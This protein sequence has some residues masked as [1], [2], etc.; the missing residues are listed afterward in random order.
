MIERPFWRERIEQSWRKAPIVWLSGVRRA[1]KTTLARSLMGARFMNCDLPS[2]AQRLLDPERA[3]REISEPILVLDEVHQLPDPS[4]L[5]KIAADEF[6]KMKVLA[7]G[8]STLA[9]TDKFRD[10]L[11][12]RKRMVH[13]GPVL[14]S[15]LAA[16]GVPSIE[17]RLFR[18]GLPGAL[19]ADD[20]DPEL[21]GE[22]IDSYFSRDIQELFRVDKRASFLALVEILLRQSGGLAEVTTLARAAAVSRPTAMSYLDILQMTHVVTLLRPFHDGGRQELLRQPKIYAFDTGFVTWSR[23]WKDLRP[24]DCGQLWEHVVLEALQARPKTGAIHFWRDKQQ[25]EVDFVLPRGRGVADAIE[26][27][28]SARAFDMRGLRAFRETHPHGRDYVVSADGGDPYSRSVEG[29]EITFTSLHDLP[30]L[31]DG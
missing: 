24:D 22:W 1:G 21:Y 20:Y 17:R 23:G 6:P 27:K 19:L 9:A 3:L 26:C 31:L 8:S 29:R 4:R 25:R 16:F 28:W 18:G 7:T 10:T 13:L 14:V 12:G 2:T 15:E 30:T 11:T 5:L